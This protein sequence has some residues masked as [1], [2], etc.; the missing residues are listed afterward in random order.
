MLCGCSNT[1]TKVSE[2]QEEETL[3]QVLNNQGE[4][5]RYL[6]DTNSDVEAIMQV[7][8]KN[9]E[10]VDN[11][12]YTELSLEK[13]M[14][15]YTTDFQ[16]TLNSSGYE[17]KVQNMYEE[18]NM[19]IQQQEVI[20]YVSTFDEDEKYC[21]VTVDAEFMILQCDETYLYQNEL[22]LNTLYIEQRVYYM[23][24]GDQWKISNIEKSVLSQKET[25]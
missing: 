23:E 19:T 10:Y 25:M 6:P 17:G 5:L 2:I 1:E 4:V 15:L 22:A 7:I 18:N 20:W 24:K 9:C 12:S 3:W 13:E 21:K 14:D 8:N 11:R 16:K